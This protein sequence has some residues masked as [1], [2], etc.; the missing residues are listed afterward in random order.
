MSGDDILWANGA[1]VTVSSEG[2]FQ[3]T[4][5]I[6]SLFGSGGIDPDTDTPISV[7]FDLQHALGNVD[8]VNPNLG[9]GPSMRG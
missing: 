5:A 9:L 3:C 6:C 7:F 1:P 2:T 4:G 8:A